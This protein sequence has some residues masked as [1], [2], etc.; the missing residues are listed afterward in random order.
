MLFFT[1]IV[2]G[3]MHIVYGLAARRL[4]ARIAPGEQAAGT[5]E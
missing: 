5:S 4:V 3:L 2:Y 1:A